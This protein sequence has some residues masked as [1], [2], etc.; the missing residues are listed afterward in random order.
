MN[1]VEVNWKFTV[2]VFFLGWLVMGL[3]RQVITPLQLEIQSELGISS[4][5]L[6]L[7]N[8]I[9]LLQPS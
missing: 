6:G 7:I 9:F 1:K 8:S 2:A 4:T 5:Q 3:T